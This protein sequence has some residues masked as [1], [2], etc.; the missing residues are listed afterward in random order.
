MLPALLLGWCTVDASATGVVQ[1]LAGLVVGV[2]AGRF[3]QVWCGP[4]RGLLSKH[5]RFK[6]T[7]RLAK[8]SS[9]SYTSAV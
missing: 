1:A 2:V 3:S 8:Y 9:R 4:A 6:C 5:Q 7:Y